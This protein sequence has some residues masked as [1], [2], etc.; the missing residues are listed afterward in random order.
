MSLQPEVLPEFE[1]P[2]PPPPAEPE[3]GPRL[4]IPHIGHAL[5]FISFAGMLLLSIQIALYFMGKAPAATTGGSIVVLH[6]KLQ[7]V[8]LAATYLSTLLGAAWMFPYLWGRPFLSGIRWQWRTAR[9]QEGRLIGLGFILG[10]TMQIVTYFITPPKKL[11]IDEFFASASTAWL[12]TVFGTLVA[13]LFEEICF[14]G[15]LVPAFAIAYDWLSMSQTE[16]ARSHWQSST[17]LTPLSYLFS[18]VL[19]SVIFALMHAEQVAH[20]WAALTGLFCVSLV[21]TFVRVKTQSVAA[22]TLVHASYNFFVFLMV[23]IATGGYRHLDR[24]I[25]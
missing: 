17:T 10:A 2:P 7:I 16:Q 11:P 22:S 21:L 23:L 6:P 1:P 18:A 5:L 4:R 19:T 12:I 24:M 14:R 15:F 25:R 9:N 20:L 3:P 13:P 8:A